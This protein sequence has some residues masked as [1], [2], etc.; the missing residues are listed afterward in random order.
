MISAHNAQNTNDAD[1]LEQKHINGR[2]RAVSEDRRVHITVRYRSHV[3]MNVCVC[4]HER[5]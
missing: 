1:K 4:V 2:V 3:T 5:V